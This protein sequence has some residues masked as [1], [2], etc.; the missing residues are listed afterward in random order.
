MIDDRSMIDDII[1]IE[2]EEVFVFSIS[3]PEVVLK[4]TYT[5]TTQL[6]KEA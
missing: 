3:F 4:S 6:K 1:H 2:K 5:E